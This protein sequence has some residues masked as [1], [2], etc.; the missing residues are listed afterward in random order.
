MQQ[1]TGKNLQDLYLPI[2]DRSACKPLQSVRVPAIDPVDKL[3]DDL[4]SG[5]QPSY[6]E[7]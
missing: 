3:A 4:K 6:L 1:I 5:E 7:H 2:T